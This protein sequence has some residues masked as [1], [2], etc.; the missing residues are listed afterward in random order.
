MTG[1][2]RLCCGLRASAIALSHWLR[3]SSAAYWRG[4]PCHEMAGTCTR[5]HI[6]FYVDVSS[7]IR[8]EF[9][10]HRREGRSRHHS[11]SGEITEGDTEA[12]KSAVKTAN[13]T[14]KLVSVSVREHIESPESFVIHWWWPDSRRGHRCGRRRTA[15]VTTAANI[16][17][18]AAGLDDVEILF[19]DDGCG[20]SLDVR[21]KAFDPFFTTRRDQ[22]STG[23]GLHIVYSIVTNCLGGKLHLESEPGKGTTIRLV[24]PRVAPAYLSAN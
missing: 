10:K 5:F 19:S 8:S 14:G 24:L 23:L 22:G 18:Q 12:F 21:R 16:K 1:N 7:R 13:D 9:E 11:I 17:V 15:D 20:M 4:R 6:P 3:N 2:S